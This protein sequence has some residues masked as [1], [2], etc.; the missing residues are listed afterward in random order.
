[1]MI[2]T[3]ATFRI[4]DRFTRIWVGSGSSP[5]RPSNIF[6]NIGTMNSSM[7]MTARIA[8]HEDDDRVGHR[9]T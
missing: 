3:I 6:A 7:P 9:A 8:M 5:P 2:G 4:A 1:M